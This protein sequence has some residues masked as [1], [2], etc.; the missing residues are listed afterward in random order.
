MQLHSL[1]RLSSVQ[2]GGEH[3]RYCC[4][5]SDAFYRCLHSAET[6]W[7]DARMH[8]A[9]AAFDAMTSAGRAATAAA[10]A[11]AEALQD[12][13]KMAN[14]TASANVAEFP[15]PMCSPLCK[16]DVHRLR[17]QPY[18]FTEKSDG[19]RVLVVARWVPHFPQW[20]CEDKGAA[21]FFLSHLSTV[22][23]LEAAR[24]ASRAGDATAAAELMVCGLPA[25]LH[26]AS[27]DCATK[28]AEEESYTLAVPGLADAADSFTVRRRCSRG[29]H[30]AFALDRAMNAAYLF[31]D[32][33][34][35]SAFH[36][37]VLDGELMCVR[38][39][40][41]AAR[42][43]LLL[44]AF[45]LFCFTPAEGSE[46]RLVAAT[47]TERYEH[48]K[49]LL[50]T[51]ANA[52]PS[53]LD[54]AVQ[55]GHTTWYA[56]TMWRVADIGAC[57]SRLRFSETHR[58]FL[59]DGPYGPT[60]NDGLIFTPDVFPVSVGSSSVQLKWK[61]RHLLSIDWLL[62]AS[63]TQADTY[64][65][66][67]FFMKKNYGH[68]DDVVGHW[69]LRK[70][71][72]ITNPHGCDMPVDAA[73]VAECAYNFGRQQWFIQRLRPDKRG[74]NSIVTAISVYESL[75]ENI[76]LP[77]LLQLLQ[78]EGGVLDDVTAAT[79][80]AET[81]EAA[82]FAGLQDA[83]APPPAFDVAQAER[84]ATATVTLRAIRE[85]RGN[86]ELYLNAYTNS[87]NKA[88]K[89]P[90]PFP[91][92]KI[93]DCA[94]LGYDPANESRSVPTL[95]EALYIQLGN[96][97][98]CYAWSDFVVDVFYNGETGYWEL[99]HL[100]PKGNNK[101]AVFDGVIEHLDWRLRFGER[102]EVAALL[103]RRRDKPL[104]VAS[105]PTSDVTQ[106]T[107]R[108]YGAVAK[109]LANAERSDLRRF[110]NWIKS[111]LLTTVA[112]AVRKTLR[113]PAKLHAVDLCCGRG[114]DLLKWQHLRPAFVF[115]T[116]ASVECVAEAAAR[117]STSEGQSLK[118]SS[119]KQRGF[120][121]FFAV[122]DAFDA[123]SG[124]RGDLV[125]RGPYQLVSCQFS[126]HYGCRSEEGMR[127]FVRAVS[128]ALVVRGRFVG[129][130]VS[131]AE[132][133]ARAKVHGA[134]YGNQVYNVHFPPE[135]YAQVAAANFEP[136]RLSFGV[137]YA[138]TVERSVQDM[139]EYV[140][141]WGAFVDLCAAHH[142]RLVLEDNF[143][144][145]YEDHK[146][147]AEGKALLAELLRKRGHDGDAT[148]LPLSA[149][150]VEAVQLYRLFVFEKTEKKA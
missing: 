59:F 69:R 20:L 72:H 31:L 13:V 75:V 14:V 24:R 29:R 102:P 124:L 46:V 35:S 98:G 139:M 77:K 89:F 16:K 34:T 93:R 138:T 86:T 64:A 106:L 133:L 78:E 129:T 150:E 12:V 26:A 33:H 97:G 6:C 68:R 94:G 84:C 92:R 107:N 9:A 21:S 32:D 143:G 85:S 48:L 128:D 99:L 120:P 63:D 114:G 149:E 146:A 116:D 118:C 130:T 22:F 23:A 105:V 134:A 3:R 111:V 140:V 19:I 70:P 121:A 8:D 2:D 43:R 58:C 82:V 15:G 44:G 40:E 125:K 122:H 47:M 57:L 80:T 96:A 100:N 91:L 28:E 1:E 141:P 42:P 117:Y 61:W 66:S 88:V 104:T 123:A 113:D 25:T 71:M 135:A 51:C 60:E 87:T 90:L 76:S 137:P 95:E 62:S 5:V 45:D 142:L 73:V 109:E 65:V 37:F 144:H 38:A 18:T 53:V 55:A 4:R 112:A 50:A 67:L 101:E 54:A 103:Q 17:H 7:T 39:A 52:P 131:D 36:S 41:A 119:G 81:L 148:E 10:P 83:A 136:G 108:H 79:T 110:N 30:F 27:E 127:S 132:L 56:K 74:A 147:T 49:A 126:M 115:M 11:S 145:F